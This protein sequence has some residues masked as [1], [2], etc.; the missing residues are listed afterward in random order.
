MPKQ[1]ESA[2]LGSVKRFFESP[3]TM[4]LVAIMATFVSGELVVPG[5]LGPSPLGQGLASIEQ[6]LALIII[7]AIGIHAL[8]A[9]LDRLLTALR[10]AGR[11]KTSSA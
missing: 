5:F 4:A 11:S 6:T 1:Q 8:A 3:L 10:H 2:V 9:E 7:A